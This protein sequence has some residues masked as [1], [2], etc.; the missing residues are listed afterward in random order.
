MANEDEG[1]AP[2]GEMAPA[3]AARDE[4]ARQA[5]L[6]AVVRH[7]A[8]GGPGAARLLGLLL[9]WDCGAGQAID[10]V[11]TARLDFVRRTLE[12]GGQPGLMETVDA[13]LGA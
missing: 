13:A 11:P 7:A 2:P 10:A 9:R 4:A 1:G 8:A 3:E 12:A 5:V 6:C